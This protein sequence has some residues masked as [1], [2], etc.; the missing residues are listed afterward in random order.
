MKK[1]RVGITGLRRAGKTVFLT[2]LIHHLQKV[3]SKELKKTTK[4]WRPDA[5]Y[6]RPDN[7][8][9][10]TNETIAVFPYEDCL[11]RMRGDSPQWPDP[12]VEESKYRLNLEL[13]LGERG[14]AARSQHTV[15]EFLDY[16]GEMLHDVPIGHQSYEAWSEETLRRL[17][18]EIGMKLD[19]F[20]DAI[21][22]AYEEWEQ[23]RQQWLHR[24]QDTDSAQNDPGK[25]A[26]E[27][28]R[29]YRKLCLALH[30][31]P[32]GP[33]RS[34]DAYR[35]VL[36][37]VRPLLARDSRTREDEWLFCPLSRDLREQCPPAVVKHMQRIYSDYA[38][39]VVRPFVR[40]LT[41]CHKH[42]VLVDLFDILSGGPVRYN[43]VQEDLN[44]TLTAF[45]ALGQHHTGL[46]RLADKM[47]RQAGR[48]KAVEQHHTGLR[49]LADK[50]RTRRP[51][52]VLF[53]ATKADQAR[54]DTR[55]NLETLLSG[56]VSKAVEGMET[57]R[58]NPEYFFA[59]A[60]RSTMNAEYRPDGGDV[61]DVLK[62]AENNSNSSSDEI[63]S[64]CPSDIPK[65]WGT[66][67]NSIWS[68]DGNSNSWRDYQ[69]VSFK[70][71][72]VPSRNDV[73]IPNIN[74][75]KILNCLLEGYL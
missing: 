5:H 61:I 10:Y 35:L 7:D 12:T 64:W 60:V 63:A 14:K 57:R 53:C 59:A 44:A 62:G 16:P 11:N 41:R 46:R 36:A 45:L 47:A 71:T 27:L 28:S 42:V 22:T 56:I 43:R 54:K 68:D 33:Q 38:D 32:T 24:N 9:L 18:T 23:V 31:T 17:N 6:A 65:E 72:R 66:Y 3:P 29:P 15:L 1:L 48:R 51:T 50:W 67:L 73:V 37:P 25:L 4:S 75:I 40:R 69:F 52:E 49:R 74:L 55:G 20:P 19:T 26:E 30:E 21:R 13:Q 2:S 34:P 39:T 70:P 58:L 8:G